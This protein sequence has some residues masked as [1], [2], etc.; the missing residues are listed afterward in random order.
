VFL[1]LER[2]P[3]LSG[4]LLGLLSYKP[5]LGVLFPI[6]LAFGGYWRAFGWASA[7]TVL[8]TVLSGI[9][10]GFDTF[11]PFIHG[12]SVI[13]KEATSSVPEYLPNLQSLYGLLRCF[14]VPEKVSW[15]LQACLSA[16]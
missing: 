14:D 15:G 2:R 7:A 4:I 1:T 11:V 12:L 5:Q 10:F 13:G 8:W 16:A 9:V 6:A 3:A